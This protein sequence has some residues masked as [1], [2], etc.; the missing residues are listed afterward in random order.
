MQEVLGIFVRAAFASGRRRARSHW[1]I[2]RSQGGAV[3][4]VQRLGDALNLNVHFHSLVPGGVYAPTP[5]GRL[6]FHVLP[7]PE[8]AEVARVATQVSRDGVL[9]G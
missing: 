7:P 9:T 8:D 2:A 4:L 3:T 6:R 1:G 5:E